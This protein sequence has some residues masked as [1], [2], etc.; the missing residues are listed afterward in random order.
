[1]RELPIR[2]QNR[3]AVRTY[4]QSHIDFAKTVL[5]HGLES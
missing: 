4:R 3:Y 5:G 1:M 2:D